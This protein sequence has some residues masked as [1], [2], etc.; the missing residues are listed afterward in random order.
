[1]NDP[2]RHHPEVL[3]IRALLTE[4]LYFQRLSHRVFD[5]ILQSVDR[6]YIDRDRLLEFVIKENLLGD[7][8]KFIQHSQG[9]DP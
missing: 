7:Y 4:G 2:F 9:L 1:M 8:E 6:I 3:R 5:E